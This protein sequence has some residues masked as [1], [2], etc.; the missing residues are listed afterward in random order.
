MVVLWRLSLELL[1]IF[2]DLRVEWVG[3]EGAVIDSVWIAESPRQRRS[4]RVP[5]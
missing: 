4:W 1:T 2:F 3:S 5:G